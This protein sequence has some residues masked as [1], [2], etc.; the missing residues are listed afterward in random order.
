MNKT[1]K[2]AEKKGEQISSCSAPSHL[3]H[4]KNACFICPLHSSTT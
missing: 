1:I 2:G 3:F 4:V